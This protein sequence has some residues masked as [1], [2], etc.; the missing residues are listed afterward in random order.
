MEDHLLR[1]VSDFTDAERATWVQAAAC[2]MVA[3]LFDAG[4]VA[5]CRVPVAPLSDLE[6]AD[7]L[8]CRELELMAAGDDPV[9]VSLQMA[10]MSTARDALRACA[11]IE[12]LPEAPSRPARTRLTGSG[13]P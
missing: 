13:L 9:R 4:N 3:A 6:F 7:A 12:A 11:A 2:R 10:V 1:R 5:A 8:A